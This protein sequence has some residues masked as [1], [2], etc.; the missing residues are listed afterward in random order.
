MSGYSKAVLETYGLV[1][2]SS[3]FCWHLLKFCLCGALG[4]LFI[5][6]MIHSQV[7]ILEQLHIMAQD[8]KPGSVKIS[9][10]D[11]VRRIHFET[12]LVHCL[13][14][15]CKALD[16]LMLQTVPELCSA[17]FDLNFHRGV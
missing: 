15:G 12:F 1:L 13:H 11:S 8:L 6:K 4:Q 10:F 16:S 3:T 7:F 14:V 9:G 2:E 17:N 5:F